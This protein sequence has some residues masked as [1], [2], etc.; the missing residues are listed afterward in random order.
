MVRFVYE[1]LHYLMILKIENSFEKRNYYLK[2]IEP[3][4]CVRLNKILSQIHAIN[5]F[6]MY[7]YKCS[8]LPDNF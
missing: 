7:R 4:L 6:V 5:H 8:E 3:W 1:K 2:M